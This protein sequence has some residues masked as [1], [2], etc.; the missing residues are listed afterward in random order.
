MLLAATF[1]AVSIAAVANAKATKSEL[2][3]AAARA[4]AEAARAE[5]VET[6]RAALADLELDAAECGRE[7]I[8]EALQTSG[9]LYAADRISASMLARLEAAATAAPDD[10]DLAARLLSLRL[11]RAR[12]QWQRRNPSL[13]D[14]SLAADLRAAVADD[15]ATALERHPE[16][17]D[18]LLIAAMLE[19]EEADA[20]PT[21]EREPRLDTALSMLDRAESASGRRFDR[22]RAML[23]TDRG[24]ALAARGETEAALAA[25]QASHEAHR[26]RGEN[27]TRDLAILETR[28]ASLQA[29]LGHD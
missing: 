22:Q 15:L 13:G 26:E 9:Q 1:A 4:D 14:L 12:I 16:H 8:M 28:M 24:D 20:L 25:Y 7:S 21:A 10:A 2:D 11:Q 23:N 27:A 6:V 3:V 18:L 19:I 17:A 29:K 5:T